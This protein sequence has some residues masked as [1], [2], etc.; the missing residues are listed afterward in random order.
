MPNCKKTFFFNNE[1]VYIER[2]LW[3]S[4]KKKKSNSESEKAAYTTGGNYR[5]CY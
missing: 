3:F 4:Y 5:P 2:F 1:P